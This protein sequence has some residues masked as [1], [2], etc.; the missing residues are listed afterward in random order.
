MMN[1]LSPEIVTHCPW[2]QSPNFEIIYSDLQDRIFKVVDFSTSLLKCSRCAS[3]YIS[4]RPTEDTIHLA[5]QDYYT[6][7]YTPPN[8]S[9]MPL[10]ARIKLSLYNGFRN[11][12]YKSS[13]TPSIAFGK[14]LYGLLPRYLNSLADEMRYIPPQK[15][16]E[17]NSVLDVGCGNCGYLHMLNRGGWFTYG[18]DFDEKTITAEPNQV[19]SLRRG[20]S[21]AWLDHSNF[22]SCIV[23]SHVLEHLHNPLSEITSFFKLLKPGGFLYLDL[24]NIDSWVFKIYGRNWRGLETP[25]HLSFPS[26]SQLTTILE[27]AGFVNI[28][29]VK[30]QITC[31]L[32]SWRLSR[33]LNYLDASHDKRHTGTKNAHRY[34]Q[35]Q[36][37]FLTLTCIKPL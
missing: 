22:F 31:E 18:C 9:K 35:C 7:N 32:H 27:A 29:Q 34:N 21:D 1:K 28:T 16:D 13:F 2:C 3:A 17:S 20:L 30:R 36:P 15:D 5:Y 25:R 33:G 8:I 19:L 24:P 37:D 26:L 23:C 6:H 4:P 12:H 14:H 10:W 11:H